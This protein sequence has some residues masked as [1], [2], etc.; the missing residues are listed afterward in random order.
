MP[1]LDY[2][3]DYLQTENKIKSL[4]TYN[5]VKESEN[6]I[7]SQQQSSMEMDA[8]QT[9]TPLSQIQ[10]ESKRFQR[11]VK[12]QLDRLLDLNQLLPENRVSGYTNVQTVKLVKKQFTEALTQI[13]SEIPQIIL[14]EMLKQLGCSQQQT[15]DVSVFNSGIFIPVESIDLMGWLKIKPNTT[16]GKLF[17]E[18][19]VRDIF[20]GFTTTTTTINPTKQRNPYNMNLEMYNRIQNEGQSYS[21]VYG[22]DYLG[23]SNLPLF[24][25]EFVTKDS[26]G[27]A[28]NFFKVTLADRD[29]TST[30]TTK[31]LVGQFIQDYFKTI[32]LVDKRLIFLLAL[33]LLFGT[34]SIQLKSGSGKIKDNLFFERLLN[35]ILGLCF[36]NRSQID[37]SGTAKVAPLDGVNDSFFELTDIDLLQLESKLSD[38]QLGVVEYQD[39]TNVKLPLNTEE[40]LNTLS[41]MDGIDDNDTAKLSDIFEKVINST[42]GNIEWPQID[43]IGLKIDTEMIKAIPKSL[44][45]AIL[46]PKVLLP[47]MTMVKALESTVGYGNSAVDRV[48]D[49]ESFM[50]TFKVFNVNVMSRIGAKFV[51]ILRDIIVRDV[52]KLLQA[53][54]KDLQKSQTTK[55]YAIISQL[56][57]SL[58]LI[59]RL[60]SDYRKCKEV[61]SDIAAII[62]FALRGQRFTLPPFLSDL[63]AF[64]TGFNDTRAFLEV[65][66]QFQKYGVPTGPMP[67]GSPNLYMLAT[68]AMIEGTEAERN[69]N[70]KTVGLLP[71]LVITPAGVTLRTPYTSIPV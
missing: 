23:L 31:N 51:K 13:Q 10:N 65:I 61:I 58:I 55:K 6:Q 35:R 33:E 38:I 44:F 22:R 41:E 47:F 8:A 62:Q 52:R 67:D 5:Q 64:R 24:N 40:M 53:V 37:V 9:S 48:N 54:T 19:K 14:D 66:Q 43:A 16:I 63:A 29:Q 4:E 12:T 11:Q 70:S 21:D 69:K 3:E 26:S 60:V 15:Y 2:N 27:V 32:K 20:T 71:S 57:E 28:G 34:L 17:Y 49:L 56:L 7:L 45:F 59:T 46:S 1:G 36:D 18:G 39:C 30:G 68:K 50:K 25:F 42:K